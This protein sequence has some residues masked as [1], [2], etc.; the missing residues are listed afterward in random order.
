M[1]TVID[2]RKKYAS[3]SKVICFVECRTTA[4][5]LHEVYF[6]VVYKGTILNMATLRNFEVM[7]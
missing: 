3:F 6:Y 4:S 2:F 5:R 1:G 7:S